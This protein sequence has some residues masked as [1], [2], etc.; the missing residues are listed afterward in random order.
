MIEDILP[1]GVVAVDTFDDPPDATLLPEEE[2]FVAKAVEK[3]RRE[4]TTARHCA[5]AALGRLGRPPAPILSGRMNEPLWPAGIVG[6][7]TH[8]AGYRGVV[9]A[10]QSVITTVGIDAEPN[11]PLTG[12]VLESVA[13][14]DERVHV[15]ELLESRPEIRWDRMLFCAKEA[16]YKAWFPLAK[17]W[18]DFED[19]VITLRPGPAGPQTGT[20]DARLLVVGP[21]VG[22]RRLT[23]FTGRW[24]VDHGLILT[25]I[26][27]P[28]VVA[29][30]QDDDR[31]AT[32]R[33]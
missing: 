12:G 4:F 24:M 27:V 10:E 6:T 21:R 18:L 28:A 31:I 1:A 23:G 17:R 16:V 20:F 15:S 5:R 26:V 30:R 19:A 25:A 8:C 9:I 2:Q 3:R 14:P 11:E 32:G 33:H 22:G 13:L 7:I 29:S